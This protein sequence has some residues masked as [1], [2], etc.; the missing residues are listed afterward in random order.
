MIKKDFRKVLP[1]V[2]ILFLSIMLSGA[3]LMAQGPPGGGGPPEGGGQPQ[4]FIT[5]VAVSS[6]T[7]TIK[8]ENFDNGDNPVVDLGEYLDLTVQPGFTATQ[9][10]ADC[11]SSPCP[12]GEFL[13]TVSTGISGN[14]FDEFDLTIEFDP[15]VIDSVKD[16]VDW[17]EVT[18]IPPGFA[19]GT[20]DGT[21]VETD[22]VFGF[23][24]AAGITGTD[25]SNWNTTYGW[26]DHSSAGYIT[27]VNAGTGLGGGGTSGDV[28]LHANTSI[29]QKR[30]SS[31]CPPGQS[32]RIISSNGTVTCEIDTD[33][34]TNTTYSPGTGLGLSGT[35][36][37]VEVPLQLSGSGTGIVGGTH[38]SGNYGFLGSS[39]YGVFGSS[40]SSIGVFGD[41][42]SSYGVRGDSSSSI[43]VSGVS[44]SS[45]GV[46]GVSSSSSGVYGKHDSSGNTGLLGTSGSGV[47]GDS[48]SGYGVRGDSSSSY[49]VFGSSSSS[50]G[51]RGDSSSSFGVFG[52]ST[53]GYGVEGKN[54]GSGN[55]GHLGS[56]TDGVFGTSSSGRGV[57][58]ESSGGI[59]GYFTS[60]SGYGLIVE[61]GNVGIGTTSP[62]SRLQVEGYVQLAHTSG[63][64]PSTDCD[65]AAERGRMK[66]DP[67]A[68]LLYI[69]VNSGWVAK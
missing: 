28:T 18:N 69:C 11:P 27:A 50:I 66:V 23:S 34:D 19:D 51:V 16:G 58:G 4:L 25:V 47:F 8:G 33:T 30:V 52:R 5:E 65:Q 6:D 42:S 68:G 15:T 57:Y 60:T 3:V 31:F 14:N 49:G 64:P 61:K 41:S 67:A 38:T 13:L 40:S 35:T 36:F 43:G 37:N 17:T 21:T 2:G 1:I 7:L 10:I 29:L 26:G 48:S 54:I 46:S 44:N 53:S 62:H 32:I 9:I 45:Y 55:Y 20:D 12:V 63:S 39:S 22:P 56:S 24:T 59:G